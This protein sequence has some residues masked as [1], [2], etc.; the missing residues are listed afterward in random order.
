MTA[1]WRPYLESLA[2]RIAS[3]APE[4]RAFDLAVVAVSD[5][6]ITPV[7]MSGLDIHRDAIREAAAGHEGFGIGAVRIHREHAATAQIQNEQAAGHCRAGCAR[8]R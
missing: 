7:E 2:I 5:T 6:H 1:P 8:E 3:S 4:I